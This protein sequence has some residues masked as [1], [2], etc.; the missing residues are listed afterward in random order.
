MHYHILY[1]QFYKLLHEII[2]PIMHIY[3]FCMRLQNLIVHLYQPH[4][5]L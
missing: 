2:K 5:N 4:L 1:I 3:N